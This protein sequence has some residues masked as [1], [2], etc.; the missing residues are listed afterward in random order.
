[1]A[2]WLTA[3]V[4][5]AAVVVGVLSLAQRHGVFSF[6][7]GAMLVLYALGLGFL[8]WGAIKG[9]AWSTGPVTAAA[10]LHVMVAASL[11][12]DSTRWVLLLGVLALVT[13]GFAVLAR[14]DF[15]RD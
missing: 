6:G 12:Q 7:I 13:A 10:V 1:M 2:G 4:A 15:E 5:L 11:A 14:R 9:R 8:A 3:L